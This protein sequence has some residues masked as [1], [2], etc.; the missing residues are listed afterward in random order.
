MGPVIGITMYERDIDWGGWSAAAA[1]L[2][3]SYVDAMRGS[4]GRPV[5]L[6]PG[7]DA[8]E[9]AATV[10][11]LDGIVIAGGADVDPASYGALAHP[12]TGRLDP[13]RDAWEFAVADSALRAG[14]PLLAIC[15]GMQV[16]NVVLGG[17][18]HQHVPDVVGHE[19]HSG[20]ASGFGKHRVRVADSGTVSGILGGPEAWLE[21][22]THH[23]QAV[24]RLG[25]GLIASAWAEDGLVEGVEP[26]VGGPEGFVIGVQWHPEQGNDPR[27]FEALV[28][29]AGRRRDGGGERAAVPVLAARAR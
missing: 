16:L 4:G 12:R 9:A 27:L 3:R 13:R 2:P 19:G 25:T 6:P 20:L 5:L 23:H 14:V 29:A 15:R 10:G 7:G 1:A 11:A 28:G 21:V 22:P 17:T 24:D 18:L 26:A 8:A